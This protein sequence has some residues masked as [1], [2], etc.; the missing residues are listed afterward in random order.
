MR[1]DPAAAF[2]RAVQ[3]GD[4]PAAD[5]ALGAL[6][7]A[8]PGNPALLYNRGLVLRRLGR[9]A[10]AVAAHD[11]A[12]ARAPEHAN[13]MFE[14]ASCLLELGRPGEAEVG[15]GAYLERRPDDTDARLNRARARLRL[16]RADD[17]LADLDG[18]DNAD[19][20][21]RLARAETL[22]D[23]RRLDEAAALLA[24]RPDD[25]PELRA[26]ALKVTTQGA[27]GR[28]RLLSG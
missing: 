6:L 13:A 10:D 22:R 23:L 19:P 8:D 27:A 14:R 20:A 9:L 5:R 11:D 16:G 15:F 24:P 12:L 1:G 26:A 2:A 18:L 25:G 28:V 17:A 4:W 21:V 3:A 7:R